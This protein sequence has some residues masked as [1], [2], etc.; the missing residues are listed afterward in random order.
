MK[1]KS[2]LCLLLAMIMVIGFIPTKSQASSTSYLV[3]IPGQFDG[4]DRAKLLN[5]INRIRKEACDERIYHKDLGRNLGPDDYSPVKW[6]SDLEATAMMRAT[7]A[8]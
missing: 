1:R 8:I 2:F 4:A 6:S 5:E 7:L 3:R